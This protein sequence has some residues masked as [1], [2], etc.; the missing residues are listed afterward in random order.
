[1]GSKSAAD[2]RKGGVI[3]LECVSLDLLDGIHHPTLRSGFLVDKMA[4]SPLFVVPAGQF[5]SFE[6]S[7]KENTGLPWRLPT[8]FGLG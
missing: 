4:L 2:T 8:L 6:R 1:M 5:A 3:S 7:K